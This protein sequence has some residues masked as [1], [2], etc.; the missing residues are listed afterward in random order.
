M[1]RGKPRNTLSI[2]ILS[3]DAAEISWQRN[4]VSL[5]TV[6]V[7]TDMDMEK[8]KVNNRS[9]INNLLLDHLNQRPYHDTLRV[10][11]NG[12]ENCTWKEM[13]QRLSDNVH[14][15]DITE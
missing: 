8:G 4:S 13:K 14:M 6:I 2:D 12:D 11:P 9:V 5:T 15:S 3:A 10:I 1:C 7:D